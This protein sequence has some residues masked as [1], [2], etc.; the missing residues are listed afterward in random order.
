[1]LYY[2]KR[3]LWVRLGDDG[4]DRAG[5]GLRGYFGGVAALSRP[6]VGVVE[7]GCCDWMNFQRGRGGLLGGDGHE[8]AGDEVLHVVDEEL[9]GDGG[10]G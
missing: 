4:R 10:A 2:S 3:C 6:Y 9:G 8:A 7:G 1:M 5:L